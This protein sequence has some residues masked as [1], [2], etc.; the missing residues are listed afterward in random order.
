MVGQG[1]VFLFYENHVKQLA[2][3]LPE[4]IRQGEFVLPLYADLSRLPEQ[5]RRAILA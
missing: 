4:R 3:D 2:P 5:E 1:C